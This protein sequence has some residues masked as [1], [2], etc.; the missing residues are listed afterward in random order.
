MKVLLRCGLL[1]VLVSA[2]GWAS[3]E[4]KTDAQRNGLTGPVRM[5]SV[6]EGKTEFEMNQTDWPVV[7]GIGDCKD[8]EYDRK[9]TLTREDFARILEARD[10]STAG[11]T[12][13]GSGLYL[14][15]VDY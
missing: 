4:K 8:C 7:L 12:A 9:G 15:N 13:P 2:A 6:R 5:V 11:P 3:D 14:V 1:M 10:R